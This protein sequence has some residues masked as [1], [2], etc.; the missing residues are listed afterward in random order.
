[1]PKRH[2]PS[3]YGF[4]CQPDFELQ[5]FIPVGIHKVLV[6]DALSKGELEVLDEVLELALQ[7]EVVASGEEPV[8]VDA[9]FD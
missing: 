8:H 2:Q 3:V 4:D 1:M 9:L 5:S 7:C 6:E